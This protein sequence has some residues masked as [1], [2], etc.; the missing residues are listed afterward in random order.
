VF[1]DRNV[2]LATTVVREVERQGLELGVGL[3]GELAVCLLHQVVVVLSP[4]LLQHI[5]H[6][7]GIGAEDGVLV[8][9]AVGQRK[10]M[11]AGNCA[12][13]GKTARRNVGRD[14]VGAQ[15]LTGVLLGDAKRFVEVRVSDYSIHFFR[16]IALRKS[17]SS[18]SRS[19]SD[20]PFAW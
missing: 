14:K 9:G 7:A 8:L 12:L 17:E 13:L 10:F 15:I 1:K 5:R 19:L 6:G 16:R 3:F 11:R 2:A 18:F 20:R 4:G